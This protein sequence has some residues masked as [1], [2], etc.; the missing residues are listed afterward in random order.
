MSAHVSRDLVRPSGEVVCGVGDE[1]GDE[2]AAAGSEDELKSEQDDEDVARSL[3]GLGG[4]ES[5]RALLGSDSV[6][7]SLSSCIWDGLESFQQ[8]AVAD[9]TQYNSKF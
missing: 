1:K 9:T 7:D 2:A 3:S 8:T 5:L 4:K 6:L